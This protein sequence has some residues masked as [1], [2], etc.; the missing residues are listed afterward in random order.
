ML[1]I[2]VN[3]ANAIALCFTTISTAP[4]LFIIV[5]VWPATPSPS[6]KSIASAGASAGPSMLYND[7]SI[8]DNVYSLTTSLKLRLDVDKINL[9]LI[10]MFDLISTGLSKIMPDDLNSAILPLL[11]I[12]MLFVSISDMLFIDA[13]LWPT[14]I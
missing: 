10:C 8:V 2:E 4:E 1:P 3:V 11:A 7:L 12:L 5:I 14:T 9:E 6:I 13:V